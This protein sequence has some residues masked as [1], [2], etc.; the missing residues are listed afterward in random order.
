MIAA[1][2]LDKKWSQCI[3]LKWNS[4]DTYSPKINGKFQIGDDPHH[5]VPKNRGR[6]VRWDL[7]N[8]VWLKRFTHTK[9]HSS[10]EEQN[11]FIEWFCRK[12]REDYEELIRLASSTVKIYLD[13]VNDVLDEYLSRYT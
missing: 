6:A 2:S 8:G 5:V 1:E 4:L 10:S 11:N 7:R 3:M 12:N 13:E 9:I